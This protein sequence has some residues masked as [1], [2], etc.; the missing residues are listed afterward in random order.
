AG[1]GAVQEFKATVVAGVG[2]DRLGSAGVEFDVA[3]V[4]VAEFEAGAGEDAEVAGEFGGEVH[5]ALFQ[6]DLDVGFDDAVE[7]VEAVVV[8]AG[9][10]G[11]ADV[12]QADGA[13]VGVD[14]GVGDAVAHGGVGR[15][16]EAGHAGVV[17]LAAEAVEVED[18]GVV[19]AAEEGE[20]EDGTL[21]VGIGVGV[22]AGVERAGDGGGGH[23]GLDT[24]VDDVDHSANG[25]AAV[26][27][28][29]VT[30]D[31]CHAFDEQGVEAD[32]VVGAG[33]GGVD[34]VCAV[35]ENAHAV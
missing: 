27:E 22:V 13:A 35:L 33:I 7:G 24:V 28:G 20:V 11:F 23:L 18:D 10:E 21:G 26:E 6:V 9:L 32:G 30:A 12:G 1:E 8:D 16:G 31:D 5:A 17:G 19:F 29:G 34:G 25:G 14:G 3:V 4:G 2:E 15:V